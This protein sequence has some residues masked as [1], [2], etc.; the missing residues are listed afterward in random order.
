MADT[1]LER[2]KKDQE[3]QKQTKEGE[4]R[5]LDEFQQ[6]FLSALE[7]I[8]EP[9]K[10]VKYIRPLLDAFK[11]V[12][13]KDTSVL[14][15]ALSLDPA[16]KAT[17]DLSINQKRKEEGKPPISIT[18]LLESKD[19]K[20]YIS[21][22]D[23]IRKGLEAGN[24]DLGLGVGTI[25]FSGTDLALNTDFLS[26]FDE[27]MKDK[28]PTQ[29][30]TWRGDLTALLVQFGVP[31]GV[32]QKILGRTKTAG[33]LKKTIEGIKGA[34]KRKVSKI[35]YRAIEGA[36][37]VGATDFLA[38]EPGRQSLFFEPESTEGLTG[39]KKAAAEFIIKIASCGF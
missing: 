1:A 7:S 10:P 28:E 8:G 19:E 5:N 33:R 9:K 36:T 30:E 25:L 29:P 14:R 39:R 6:T 11:G 24:F 26:K 13:A 21:G 22:F 32:I 23:E 12:D 38:S 27:F 17:I 16:L 15:F 37:V 34:N 20:D 4:I 2:F 35:A 3:E 31:G 18:D